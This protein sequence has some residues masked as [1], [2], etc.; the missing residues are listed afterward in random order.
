MPRGKTQTCGVW[1]TLETMETKSISAP[2][3]P[4]PL[5]GLISP[6]VVRDGAEVVKSIRIDALGYYDMDTGLASLSVRIATL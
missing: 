4:R 3:G 1:T 2:H 5:T 6:R